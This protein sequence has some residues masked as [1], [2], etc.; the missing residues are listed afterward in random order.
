MIISLLFDH[1]LLMHQDQKVMLEN[2][3]PAITVASLREKVMMESLTTF[4]EG[5]VLSEDPRAVFEEYSSK[6]SQLFD[7]RSSI[8]HM[9]GVDM[10]FCTLNRTPKVGV[11]V[12]RHGGIISRRYLACNKNVSKCIKI[13]QSA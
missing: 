5:I 11:A 13:Y 9:G 6:I 7:L 12:K 2:K 8:K 4:I 3:K 10:S 1:A